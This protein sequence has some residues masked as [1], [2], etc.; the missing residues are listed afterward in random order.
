[1]KRLIY[2]FFVLALVSCSNDDDSSD[3]GTD[4]SG[5]DGKW[6]LTNVSGGFVGLDH[7]FANGTIVWDFN[8]A[9]KTV[10]IIN[11]NADDTIY[12]VL[13]TGEYD[14]SIATV[15]GIKEFAVDG[16]NIGSLELLINEF[17]IEEQ[18]RDGFRLK[19]Q[20]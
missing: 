5:L 1:M 6:N 8:E 19:F 2:I 12:D 10:N 9:N 3:T 20:R 7:D 11:T 16:K 17:T 13:P 15:N 18:L 4:A 14:Y